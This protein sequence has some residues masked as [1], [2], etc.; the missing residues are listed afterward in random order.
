MGPGGTA[1]AGVPSGATAGGCAAGAPAGPA[2]AGATAARGAAGRTAAWPRI[3]GKAFASGNASARAVRDLRLSLFLTG[4]RLLGFAIRIPLRGFRGAELRVECR[5]DH[6]T[7]GM[8]RL[9]PTSLGPARHPGGKRPP[10]SFPIGTVGRVG[11]LARVRLQT[12]STFR[13]GAPFKRSLSVFFV[14]ESHTASIAD[15]RSPTLWD[16]RRKPT[17]SNRGYTAL[18]LKS[19]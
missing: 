12:T 6:Q 11:R 15:A 14:G 4:A 19:R 16:G 7:I 1:A 13:T 18:K 17:V 2:A 8:G 3:A 5:P 10:H 9:C